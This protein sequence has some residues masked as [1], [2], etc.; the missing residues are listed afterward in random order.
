MVK[1][2]GR[3]KTWRKRWFRFDRQARRLAYYAGEAAAQGQPSTLGVLIQPPSPLEVW[4]LVPLSCPSGPGDLGPTPCSLLSLLP[5]LGPFP[6]HF[7][8]PFPAFPTAQQCGFPLPSLSQPLPPT[9]AYLG[10][11]S[12]AHRLLLAAPFHR[13]HLFLCDLGQR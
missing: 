6:K 9:Q 3:I 1:M 4:G 12:G 5:G 11:E 2:G 7:P 10:A 8:V 13:R